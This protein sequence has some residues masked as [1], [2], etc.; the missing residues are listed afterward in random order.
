MSIPVAVMRELGRKPEREMLIYMTAFAVCVGAVLVAYVL[1]RSRVGLAL[2]AIRDNEV[3]SSSLGVKIGRIKLAVYVAAGAVTAMIGALIFIT[4][5]RISPEAAFSVN[6]WT[7]FVIFIVVIGGI[8]RLEGP[9][10]GTLPYV[11]LREG[12]ADLGRPAS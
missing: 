2:T 5:L 11:L 9:I 1:L 7:V 12:L 8:G 6:D 10:L 4:K 3:A